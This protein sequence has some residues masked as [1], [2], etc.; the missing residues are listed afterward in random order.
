MKA[1]VISG[2]ILIGLFFFGLAALYFLTPAGSLPD[3]V[4]GYEQGSTRVHLT[5][6][7]G[8]A[9]IGVVAFLLAWF[10]SWGD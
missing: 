9:A 10:R 4:P 5:H 3:F 1:V 2:A 8:M 6:A 7:L